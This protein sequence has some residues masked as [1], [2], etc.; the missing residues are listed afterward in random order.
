MTSTLGP[1]DIGQEPRHLGALG[2]AIRR[3]GW[4][5]AGA[6]LVASG[7]VTLAGDRGLETA[8]FAYLLNFAFFL[9]LALGGLFFV[10]VQHLTNAGWSVV[11][12]RLAEGFAATLP[13]LA[14]AFVP[15]LLG[16]HPLYHWSHAEAVAA[17]PLLQAKAPYLNTGFF[18]VRWVGY[19][20]AWLWMVRYFVGRSMAQDGSGD[21][22]L[23]VQMQRRAALAV[24]VYAVTVTF[25]AFDLLM[26]LDPHWYSTIFGVYFFA[27]AFLGAIALLIVVATGLQRAGL[28]R[29]VI[30]REHYHDLGKLL[31]AFVVFWAYIAFSQYMLIWYGNIP[32]ETNWFL[33]RQTNGWGWVGLALVFGHFVAPFVAL[34]SRYSKRR[35]HLLVVAAAWV[36]AMHWVDLFWIVM[37]QASPERAAFP[38]VN[39]TL[40]VSLGGVMAA[41]FAHRLRERALVPERDPRLVESLTFE[42]A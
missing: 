6:G 5:A 7:A 2:A 25:A 35:K 20:A 28:L 9:S 37:P 38:L 16:L 40:L 26:S 11:V 19:F 14:V 8:A 21:H 30:T 17:D 41:S 18:V 36:L 1:V 27:G 12:R 4:F 15:L 32:E 13:W 24:L 29:R 3:W 39:L 10:L 42:N 31:F 23:T 22:R 33:R 34:L